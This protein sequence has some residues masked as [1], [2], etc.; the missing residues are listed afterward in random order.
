VSIRRLPEGP[1]PGLLDRTPREVLRE[2]GTTT[3]M[4]LPG[5]D[6]EPARAVVTLLHGDE[7]TGLE[8]LLTVLR[9]RQRF[10]FD[11]HVVL[12]NVEAA[13]HGSGFAHRYLDGQE[14]GNRIWERPLPDDA[15]AQRRAADAVLDDVLA[16]PLGGMIDVHNTTGANPFHGIVADD[17][18][19]SLDI[20]TRFSTTLLRWDL[21]VGTIIEAVAP[22]APVAAVEC[23]LPGRRASTAFAVDGLR[24]FLGPPPG[25]FPPPDHDLITDLRRVE[26]LPDV[27]FR[28]GGA[29][30]DEAELT[31]VPDGDAANLREVTAGHVLGHI[32]PGAPL[33]LRVTTPSGEE[34]TDQLLEV[35]SDGTVVTRRRAVPVMVVRTVDAVRK[36]CLC[37]LASADGAAGGSVTHPPFASSAA[38][39][40]PANRSSS[41]PSTGTSARRFR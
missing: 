2:L 20:A 24:R 14:D 5:T 22:T 39:S 36:D 33:P 15:S 19:A 23:G 9:R 37:Y 35:T 13:L 11:L 16:A 21:G 10:P 25:A 30:D 31:L 38:R 3:W 29:P 8:A 27:R 4:R 40:S 6:G 7:S 41:T 1:P 32:R 26:V 18:P 17:R 12:G 34:V 28:F